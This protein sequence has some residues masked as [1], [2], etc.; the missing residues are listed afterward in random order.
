MI[1]QVAVL[2]ALGLDTLAVGIS[3]GLAGIPTSHRVRV[4]LVLAVYSL[5]MP[6]IGL[7][8]GEALSESA[9]TAATYLAG[10]GLIG[11]G[12]YGLVEQRSAARDEATVVELVL[13][14]DVIHE[15]ALGYAA[16][17]NQSWR[18]V[19]ITA[20]L[21]SVDKLAVGLALGAQ[22]LRPVGALIY[23]TAQSFV[24]AL[25]GMAAGRSLGA[26]L[27]HR[28]ELASKFLLIGVGIAIVTS[29]LLDVGL[30]TNA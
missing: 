2:L 3:F 8:A 26:T 10:L 20:M 6:S 11:A 1:A 25:A 30:I 5:L 12:L 4:G 9:A 27:G 28:A 24:L 15:A 22:D 17:F 7:L 18:R 21:G 16:Q 13:H 29:Q 14:E 23:L 19:H